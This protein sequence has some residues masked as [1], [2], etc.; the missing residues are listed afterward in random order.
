M[1]SIEIEQKERKLGSDLRGLGDPSPEVR[2]RFARRLGQL[3]GVEALKAL[4]EASLVESNILCKIEMVRSVVSLEEQLGL[5][6]MAS[7]VLEGAKP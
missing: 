5:V 3:G 4:K 1:K 2:A 7:T 6:D